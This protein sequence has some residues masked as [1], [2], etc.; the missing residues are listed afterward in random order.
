MSIVYLP[1]ILV[2]MIV[3]V[4]ESNELGLL[5][6]HIWFVGPFISWT[7]MTDAPYLVGTVV[8]VTESNKLKLLTLHIWLIGSFV[9]WTIM[10]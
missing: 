7:I 5:M 3:H 4:T 2:G 6:L 10:N 9:S 8:N 1:S